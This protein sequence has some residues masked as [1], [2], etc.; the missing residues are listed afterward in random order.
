MDSGFTPIPWNLLS[1]TPPGPGKT[2]TRQN[3]R[4]RPVR[5]HLILASFLCLGGT[6]A[7]VWGLSSRR[8]WQH[9]LACWLVTVNVIAFG[10]FGFDKGQAQNSGARVPEVVLY[11]LAAAGGSPGAFLAMRIFHHKTI[12]GKFRLLFWSIVLIQAA[13]ILWLL[14]TWW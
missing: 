5:F 3:V 2:M 4:P 10:Y 13:L 9:W 11:S 8:D 14:K 7:L 6:L 1:P 12:K